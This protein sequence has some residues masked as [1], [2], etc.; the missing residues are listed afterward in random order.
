VQVLPSGLHKDKQCSLYRCHG[1]FWLLGYMYVFRALVAG[2]MPTR[3]CDFDRSIPYIRAGGM[4][5]HYTPDEDA[6]AALHRRGCS[7][8]V[9]NVGDHEYTG[10]GSG[11]KNSIL[12]RSPVITE[13][14]TQRLMLECLGSRRYRAVASCGE[15]GVT[16]PDG[17]AAGVTRHGA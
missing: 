13:N 10:G 17:T 5:M 7:A 3:P 9:H 12:I 4:Q 6:V 2:S 11:C 16:A 8:V 14:G 1:G 15:R